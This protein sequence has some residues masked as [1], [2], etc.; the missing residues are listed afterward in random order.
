MQFASQ[1]TLAKLDSNIAQLDE[2]LQYERQ[3]FES[4]SKDLEEDKSKYSL[5]S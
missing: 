2:K 5:L 4:Y 1:K 3:K